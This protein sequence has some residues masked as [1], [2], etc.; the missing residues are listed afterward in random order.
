MNTDELSW[1]DGILS[2]IV[3]RGSGEIHIGC[4]LYISDDSRVR[5]A[6][7]IF[8]SGVDSV[9]C[10]IDFIALIDNARA[11]NITNGRVSTAK[12]N[13]TLKIFFADGYLYIKAKA[14]DIE[15]I[16]YGSTPR[17]AES[18]QV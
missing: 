12:N 11:G 9:S 16:S 8:C 6:V 18:Q 15:R 10:S 2:E 1:H 7:H 14:M 4:D 5:E 17:P 13:A 3:I